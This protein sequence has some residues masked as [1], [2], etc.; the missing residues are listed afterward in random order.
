MQDHVF[1]SA[2]LLSDKRADVAQAVADARTAGR[3]G[4][5]AG[6]V[7]EFAVARDVTSRFRLDRTRLPPGNALRD[8]A[9]DVRNRPPR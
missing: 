6:F 5:E 4:Q 3:N 9:H 2:D 7:E 1:H 8:A